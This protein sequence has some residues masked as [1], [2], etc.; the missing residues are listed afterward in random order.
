MKEILLICVN[1]NSY[2]ALKS[3]LGSVDRAAYKA[4]T[5]CHVRVWIADNSEEKQTIETDTYK[6]V[7]CYYFTCENEGYIG[8]VEKLLKQNNWKDLNNTDYLII[9]NVDI[10]FAEDTLTQIASISDSTIGW[11]APRIYSKCRN[12][13]E[14]PQAIYRYSK[15][16]LCLMRWIYSHPTLYKIY[17]QTIHQLFQNHR[18]QLTTQ[19]HQLDIYAGNGSIFIFTKAFMDKITPFHYPCFLYGEELFFAELVRNNQLKTIYC[20]NIYIENSTP[21]VSTR[22]LGYEKRCLYTGKAIDY[23]LTTFY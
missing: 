8:T 10:C 4:E 19:Q 20:P 23:I 17:R 7:D 12:T 1:Y 13:E 22:N 6:H 14:N 5:M 9:S 11:I 21:N 2:E 18:N 16:K 3:F 15:T